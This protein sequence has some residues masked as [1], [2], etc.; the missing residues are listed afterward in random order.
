VLRIRRYI[1][2]ID[3]GEDKLV[4]PAFTNELLQKLQAISGV[5]DVWATD[6]NKAALGSC[7]AMFFIN[8]ACG[9]SSACLRPAA[10]SAS[11]GSVNIAV[12]A[13]SGYRLYNCAPCCAYK[14]DNAPKAALFH[15]LL[16]QKMLSISWK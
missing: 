12:N 3:A 9:E 2:S 5:V 10:R 6:E 4:S 11:A 16:R 13:C 8:P 14:L 7:T 1:L 15:L